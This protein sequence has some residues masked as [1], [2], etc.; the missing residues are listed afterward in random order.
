MNLKVLGIINEQNY[1]FFFKDDR[2]VEISN[3]FLFID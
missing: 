1:Y 3:R 2:L